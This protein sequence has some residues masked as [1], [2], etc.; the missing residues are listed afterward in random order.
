MFPSDLRNEIDFGDILVR[1]Q[2]RIITLVSMKTPHFRP[3][4]NTDLLVVVV[5]CFCYTNLFNGQGI[6]R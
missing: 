4:S 6:T 1:R 2:Q 3:N 5:L